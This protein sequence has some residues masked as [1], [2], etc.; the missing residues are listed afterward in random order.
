MMI[1]AESP[2]NVASVAQHTPFRHLLDTITNLT[3]ILTKLIR[4]L[5]YRS[6]RYNVSRVSYKYHINL[7][8]SSN[9]LFSIFSSFIL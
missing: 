8:I 9:M 4:K 7:Q 6:S 3:Y 5:R 2:Y 1:K